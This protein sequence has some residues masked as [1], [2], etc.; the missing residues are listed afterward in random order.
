MTF[1]S[2]LPKE[3]IVQKLEPDHCYSVVIS[4]LDDRI[5]E[6]MCARFYVEA[7][8]NTKIMGNNGIYLNIHP[9]E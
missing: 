3:L 8:E 2:K 7:T 1:S 5:S 9:N 6:H 4:V